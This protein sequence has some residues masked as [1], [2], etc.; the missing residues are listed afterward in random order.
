MSAVRQG[1][2]RRS[3]ALALV[4]VLLPALLGGQ[5]GAGPP[6][7]TFDAL[8]FRGIGPAAMGGRIGALAVFDDDPS[9]FYVGTATGGLWKTINGGT[10]WQVLFDREPDVVSIGDVAV[11]QNAPDLVWVGTGENNNRQSSSWGKG[12]YKSTDGGRTWRHCG[13]TESRHVGRIVI[14]PNDHDVVYVAAAGSLWA[15]G[16]NRGVFKT[17]DGGA[18]WARILYVD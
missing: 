15:E 4:S 6:A 9:T 13:L 2:P 7:S 1:D 5:Q 8:A 10:T 12:V 17:S 16:G 3:L 18:T 14:D 11:A